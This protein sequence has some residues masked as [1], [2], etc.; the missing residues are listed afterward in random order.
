MYTGDMANG[1]GPRINGPKISTPPPAIDST[2][3]A[4]TPSV[5]TYLDT[6]D[7]AELQEEIRRQ[8]EE[9]KEL[10]IGDMEDISEEESAEWGDGRGP[11]DADVFSE[12]SE[13]TDDNPNLVPKLA[14]ATL[15]QDLLENVH[16]APSEEAGL[17]QETLQKLTPQDQPLG[18]EQLQHQQTLQ[19]LPD[20]GL[21]AGTALVSSP[22]LVD[23]VPPSEEHFHV[24]I[25]GRDDLG[26]EVI[27][28]MDALPL[29]PLYTSDSGEASPELSV[30]LGAYSL[31]GEAPAPR[32]YISQQSKKFFSYIWSWLWFLMSC[33][34]RV[35]KTPVFI[36]IHVRN[37]MQLFNSLD[38]SPF[39]ERDMDDD[40]V[41]Y[42]MCDMVW[43]WGLVR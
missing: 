19:P 11:E 21:V 5:S 42:I 20:R 32:H 31:E 37:V 43:R 35:N 13:R 34:R 36:D 3:P 38:P 9:H 22:Q 18:H 17:P 39:Q 29:R 33:C 16:E 24:P 41:E 26:H 15:P 27:I 2:V 40:A 14:A 8:M 12:E 28:D 1:E 10:D 30:P 6:N 7:I 25:Q 23:E 4:H